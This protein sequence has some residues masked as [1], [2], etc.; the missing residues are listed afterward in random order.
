MSRTTSK[1]NALADTISG[2]IAH[3]LTIALIILGITATII[4]TA[5]QTFGAYQNELEL[6]DTRMENIQAAHGQ[7]LAASVWDFSDKQ[8]KIELEG[9]LNTPDVEFV[10]V[11]AD[12]GDVWIAGE[13]ISSEVIV[14]QIPL[15]ITKKGTE[16][17]LA[18]LKVVVG[19]GGI[20]DRLFSKAVE[21]LIYF[22]IW[23]FF[24]AGSLFLIFRQLVTRHLETLAKY[25][26]SI[27][28]ENPGPPVSLDR[29]YSNPD[30]ADELDQVANAIN[31]MRR[32]LAGSILE[33]RQSE[34]S[35]RTTLDSIGDAVIATD[36]SGNISRMN[37]IAEDL[38]GWKSAQAIGKP[39]NEVFYI[40]KSK[41]RERAFNP[42]EMVL[43]SGKIVGMAYH[44]ILIAKNG[45]EHQIADSAAPIHNDKGVI[46]GVVL[47]FRDVTEEHAIQEDLRNALV[48]AERANEAKSEFLASMSHELRT[49]LNAV[50]GFAQM[51]QYD[52]KNPLSSHQNSH[53]ESILEGGSHLLGLVN[54]ILD[55]ARIEADQISLS[56]EDIEPEKIVSECISLTHP[57][58]ES[59]GITVIVDSADE[60]QA[61]LR[62]DVTR[63]KQALLNLLSNAVKFNKVDGTVKINTR[64]LDD[65]FLR[66]SVEDTG[67]GIAKE[68]FPGVFQIFNRL[69]ADP[70]IAQEGTGIGLPVTKL[71]VERMSGR[72]GFESEEGVGSTF[73]IELPLATNKEVLIW[74]DNLRIGV[75]AIDKDHQFLIG[76]SNKIAYGRVEDHT[77]NDA[78]GELIDYVDF[79][80]KREEVI[81]KTCAFPD[82]EE[83]SKL[84]RQ[85]TSQVIDISNEWRNDRNEE[86]IHKLRKFLRQWLVDHIM[87]TDIN[88]AKY[89]KGKEKDIR[90]ALEKVG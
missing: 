11:R 30:S 36:T 16:Q 34:E 83:H 37:P 45:R 51:L 65:D 15:V 25:T 2:T 35:L 67:A 31:T 17:N 50:L 38:T 24:L 32:Q 84:H 27:S 6:V 20:Y 73:W 79:H 39:L 80:F 74:A 18:T 63:L 23:T 1:K 41:T 77:L 60:P 75:D 66:I 61:R 12:E 68:D 7:S 78:I 26:A 89:T 59:K 47:V 53:V 40:L 33:L 19:K 13:S 85:L 46:T 52:P 21:T 8:I 82:L 58:F 88:I 71:L 28:F 69:N 56:L 9:L 87:N 57:L 42:V 76:L 62:T 86:T 10:E 29:F 44:T 48:D 90:V 5:V 64:R 4:T 81:M 70:M 22:G 55:L 14:K 43:E 3:R 49:P 54:E 72:V